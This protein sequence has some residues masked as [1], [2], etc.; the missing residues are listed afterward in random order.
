MDVHTYERWQRVWTWWKETATFKLEPN[1]Y[2]SIAD[3]PMDAPDGTK[4]S[5]MD[6]V[7]TDYDRR[8]GKWDKVQE[9]T[10]EDCKRIYG[11]D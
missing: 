8:G 1:W 7:R 10:E 4:I 11:Q 3:A 6:E 9:I 2:T 5:V